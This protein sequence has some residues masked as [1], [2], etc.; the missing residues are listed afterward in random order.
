MDTSD[1]M[2]Q[3]TIENKTLIIDLSGVS[4]IDKPGIDTLV[5]VIRT[6]QK[7]KVTTSLAMC[8]FHLVTSLDRVNFADKVKSSSHLCKLYPT[9]HDAVIDSLWDDNTFDP[10]I[11]YYADQIHWSWYGWFI[12]HFFV[13][14]T[15]HV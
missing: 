15:S 13:F 5:E 7:Q 9:I 3:T 12:F 6:L 14:K 10:F 2:E 4:F 11:I 8:P 1:V